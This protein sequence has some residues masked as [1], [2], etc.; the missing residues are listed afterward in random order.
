MNTV[1]PT[2][3]PGRAEQR[4]EALRSDPLYPH[5]HRSVVP[6]DAN[7]QVNLLVDALAEIRSSLRQLGRGTRFDANAGRILHDRTRSLPVHIQEDAGFWRWLAIEQGCDIIEYRFGVSEW[8]GI[9][10]FGLGGRWDNLFLRLWF[11]ADIAYDS[12][13][14][15]PYQLVAL[16]DVDFWVSGILRHRYGSS[17]TLAKA[18]V[19]F[20][21]P[22]PSEPAQ[23]RWQLAGERSRDK[24]IRVLYK[25]L[26]RLHAIVAYETLS[27]DQCTEILESLSKNLPR[28][29]P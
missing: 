6:N 5:H 9:G 7:E 23:D 26:R 4:L 28:D 21:Y 27:V 16:G 25:N 17:R 13:E 29:H 19:K 1:Y 20:A 2:L 15:S 22:D 14:D 10:N 12:S 11:R 8:A 3:T 24:G 18:F